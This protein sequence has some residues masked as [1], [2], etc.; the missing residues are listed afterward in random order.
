MERGLDHECGATH[1]GMFF[2]W[3]AN[4]GMVDPNFT[5]V[6]ALKNRTVTPGRF[7]LDHCAGE[8]D[9]FMLTAAAYKPYVA[10]YQYIPAV[11]CYS[12]SYAAPDS[13]ELFDAVAPN[14]DETYR[15]HLEQ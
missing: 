8:I 5:D 11:A 14:I 13:W 7:L 12:T 10:T 2:A 6:A 3:L 4:H 9:S 1:I 15:T